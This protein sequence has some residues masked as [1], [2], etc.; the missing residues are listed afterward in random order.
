MIDEIDDN[1]NQIHDN[2]NREQLNLVKNIIQYEHVMND[3]TITEKHKYKH[4]E[5][6]HSPPP[7]SASIPKSSSHKDKR[8]KINKVR[9]GSEVFTE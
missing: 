2:V 7:P 5:Q 6:S 9:A 3:S 1:L 8:D 4:I